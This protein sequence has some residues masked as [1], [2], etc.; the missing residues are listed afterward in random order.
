M[1]ID[2]TDL[3][4]TAIEPNGNKIAIIA[5]KGTDEKFRLPMVPRNSAGNE[6]FTAAKPGAVAISGSLVGDEH[7]FHDAATSAG[8]GTTLTLN[9]HNRV[10]VSISRT[11]ITAN[12]LSFKATGPGGVVGYIL[13]YKIE[14]GGTI[15]ADASSS[16]LTDE[17]W[18]FD[19]LAGYTNVVISIDSMAGTSI[20]IKGRAVG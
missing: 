15:T 1:S 13:G 3:L 4:D 8:S 11:A 9:G 14:S 10:I 17:V 19:D 12:V 20:T 7:T 16:A 2:Y 18:I 6:I 5:E